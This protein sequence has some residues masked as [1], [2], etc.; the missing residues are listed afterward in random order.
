MVHTNF[1]ADSI[2][3]QVDVLSGFSPSLGALLA[4]VCAE[5]GEIQADVVSQSEQVSLAAV[6][7]VYSYP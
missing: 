5:F 6:I 2:A 1:K 7:D 4:T 3:A